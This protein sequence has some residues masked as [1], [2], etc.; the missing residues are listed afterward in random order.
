MSAN[1]L[2]SFFRYEKA[3]NEIKKK[4]L[5]PQ[6][7]QA[8]LQQHAQCK[9]EAESKFS[10]VDEVIA[11]IQLYQ[12]CPNFGVLLRQA[13][14]EIPIKTFFFFFQKR[15]A[16]ITTSH[17]SAASRSPIR[18]HRAKRQETDERDGLSSRRPEFCK[19]SPP[20]PAKRINKFF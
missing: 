13:S 10:K 1:H 14:Q 15:H 18:T 12:V 16:W 3:E 7:E 5:N 4:Q 9:A 20:P 8:M 17:R 2:I 11:Q 19:C 6:V